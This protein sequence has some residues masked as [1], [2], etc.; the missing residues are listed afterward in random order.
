MSRTSERR[1]SGPGLAVA[2]F[3][4]AAIWGSVATRFG[5]PTPDDVTTSITCVRLEG[6]KWVPAPCGKDAPP[7]AQQAP[8]APVVVPKTACGLA[9]EA[10]IL[11]TIRELESGGRY[12]IGPNA[13]GA[14]GAYQFIQGTWNATAKR[15][16]RGDL[17]GRGPWTASP[18]DQDAIARQHVTEALGGTNDIGRV[19]VIWYYPR[20]LN[21]PGLMDVVPHPE[22][23]NKLTPNQYRQKWMAIYKRMGAPCEATA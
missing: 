4:L 9:G 23:G 22:A 1:V 8:D 21:N 16:G 14:S 15:A 19:P 20:A 11:A 6:G 13:G 5:L 18:A 3:F 17:V 2:A 7:V 10:T 12:G